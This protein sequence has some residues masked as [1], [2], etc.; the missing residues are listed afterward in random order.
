MNIDRESRG[1]AIVAEDVDEACQ[2]KGHQAQERSLGI[3]MDSFDARRI[4]RH[5][6]SDVGGLNNT[7]FEH[8]EAKAIQAQEDL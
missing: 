1:T 2:D 4:A 3:G 6:E 8:E 5:R 7:H